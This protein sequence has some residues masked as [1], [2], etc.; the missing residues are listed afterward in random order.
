MWSF[1]GGHAHVAVLRRFGMD[2]CRVSAWPDHSAMSHAILRHASGLVAGHYSY[3]DCHIDRAV[4]AFAGHGSTTP[5]GGPGSRQSSGA[6]RRATATV[7]FDLLSISVGSRPQAAGV[8]GALQHVMPVKPSIPG[9]SAGRICWR[10][11]DGAG[12]FRISVVGG[13]GRRVEMALSIQHRLHSLLAARGNDPGQVQI[14]L[15]HDAETPKTT[16]RVCVEWLSE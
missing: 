8:E 2:R 4:G 7:N 15:L 9:C 1:G 14:E 12:V 10:V 6:G 13:G 5:G 11:L 3:D 16:V